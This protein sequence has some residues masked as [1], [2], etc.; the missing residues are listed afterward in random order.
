M[1][2]L[3][4][5]RIVDLCAN[6][7]THR[8]DPSVVIILPF[9]AVQV[10]TPNTIDGKTL[11]ANPACKAV[12]TQALTLHGTVGTIKIHMMSCRRTIA[13]SLGF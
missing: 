5:M 8:F 13:F 6:F 12:G 10:G 4:Q 11:A 7:W 3:I 9:A 2:V 1:M